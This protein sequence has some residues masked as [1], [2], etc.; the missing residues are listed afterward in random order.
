MG[1]LNALGKGIKTIVEEIQKP[2]S[3]SK[4]EA[5]EEYL[6]KHTFPKDRYKL[7]HRT[8]N[9]QSNK[10]DFAD[11]SLYPDYKFQCIE[12]G[13]VFFVEA[14]FREGRY[15][16]NKIEWCKPYQLKRYKQ[17]DLH[18]SP[19][20]LALGIGDAASKPEEIF[21]IPLKK[22]EY[23]A[24]FDSFLNKYSFYPDKP[25]FASHLWKL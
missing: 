3:F 15:Y 14:K 7:I 11:S 23:C 21:L 12:T 17:I 16:Q 1:I 20:F 5:F 25:V 4:G 24:F 19:V 8:H 2:E 18:E 9:Y 22:I 6:R 13:K 10:E